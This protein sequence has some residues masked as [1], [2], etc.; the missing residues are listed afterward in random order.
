MKKVFKHFFFR[1]PGIFLQKNEF[2]FFP[3][4]ETKKKKILFEKKKSHREKQKRKN[5]S[6]T[7]TTQ[8]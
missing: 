6:Q 5:Q 3:N 7:E 4:L 8:K 2:D 1:F